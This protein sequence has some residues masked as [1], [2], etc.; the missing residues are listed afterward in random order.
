[1]SWLDRIP[2]RNRVATNITKRGFHEPTDR[3]LGF[4]LDM[5]FDSISDHDDRLDPRKNASYVRH[6]LAL[7]YYYEATVYH[8]VEGEWCSFPIVYTIYRRDRELRRAEIVDYL[9]HGT[10]PAR[11]PPRESGGVINEPMNEE[12]FERMMGRFDMRTLTFL[13]Y[14]FDSK[15]PGVPTTVERLYER[16][17]NR[18]VQTHCTTF[19]ETFW[20]H[21]SVNR[22]WGYLRRAFLAQLIVEVR[23][24]GAPYWFIDAKLRAGAIQYRLLTGHDLRFHWAN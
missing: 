17:S 3:L 4:P 10:I 24:A 18:E 15:Y 13:A 5:C 8:Q 6:D 1:M 20:T 9:R 16:G 23:M 11:Y 2:P 7:K 21:V 14:S 19:E 12:N 22:D